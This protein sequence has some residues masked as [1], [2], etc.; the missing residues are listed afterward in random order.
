M[1][2]DDAIAIKLDNYFA[3]GVISQPTWI[4]RTSRSSSRLVTVA[5]AS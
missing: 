5:D 1:A 3:M 2:S 4:V